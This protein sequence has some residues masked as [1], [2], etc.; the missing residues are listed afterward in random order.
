MEKE[1]LA[2][3]DCWESNFL[4]LDYLSNLNKYSSECLA[5]LIIAVANLS[6]LFHITLL[7]CLIKSILVFENSDV[8]LVIICFLL[9]FFFRF[10]W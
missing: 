3:Q 5:F 7:L 6:C 2:L 4:S 10:T 1:T 8:Y 9:F